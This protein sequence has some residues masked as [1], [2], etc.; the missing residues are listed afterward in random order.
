MKIININTPEIPC[1]GTHHHTATK[2]CSGFVQRGYEF[3]EL[4]SLNDIEKYNDDKNL[5]LL[6][7]H[8][9][10][11][12]TEDFVY[13]LAEKLDKCT[14]IAWHLFYA[15]KLINN[16]PFKK[17]ITTGE[18]FR[19]PPLS[20][21][22]H[23]DYYNYSINS[24]TYVPFEF[25]SPLN[26]NDVGKLSRSYI[27]DSCFIGSGYKPHWVSRLNNCYNHTSTFLPENERINIYLNSKVCLGFHSDANILNSCIVERVFEGMGLGCCVISDNPA[28]TQATN[29][30]VKYV[31]SFEEVL[32][33]I[34][35]FKD[36]KNFI[37]YQKMG[38]EFIKE[39]GTYHHLAGKFLN[40]INELYA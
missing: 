24:K 30:I 12:N 38:Y 19:N 11:S 20:S 32:Y 33:Y 39:Q 29:D 34:D 10:H 36:D 16:I 35:F 17:Y 8:F 22:Q 7:N 5:I 23:I 37:E 1:P 13:I 4:N 14:F 26:P 3:I 27:Y 28:V 2:F 21:Q 15:E 9:A 40:K 31:S 6:S 18:Y 25:L